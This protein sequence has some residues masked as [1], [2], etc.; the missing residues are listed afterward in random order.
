MKL[1]IVHISDIHL[2]ATNLVDFKQYYLDALLNDLE[3]LNSEKRIDIVCLTGDL[4]DKGGSS[5]QVAG[6]KY[7]YFIEN[8]WKPIS[9]KLQINDDR[10]FIIP[11]NHDLDEG[12]IDE[13][14]ESGLA[15]KLKTIEAVNGFV[16]KYQDTEYVA[17]ER[18]KEYKEFERAFYKGRTESYVSNFESCHVIEVEGKRIGLAC[19]NTSWRCY[20]KQ[21]HD[22]LVM[23]PIQVTNASAYF[24]EKACDFVIGMMHHPIDFISSVDRDD[25]LS[26]LRN[27]NYD[28]M[29]F[30]HTHDGTTQYQ[31]GNNG[32][33]FI[34]TARTGFNNP[35]ETHDKYKS[36]Y[37]II[38]IDDLNVICHYRLYV[39]ERLKFDKDIIQA[40]N[41]EFHAT[42]LPKSG[43][44]EFYKLMTIS[45]ETCMSRIDD[46]NESLVIYGTDSKAPK[47][48]NDLF[49]L[50]RLTDAPISYGSFED[51][52]YYELNQLI[53]S[54]ENILLSGDKES[55]K[56]T[57]LNKL[58]IEISNNFAIYQKIP[59]KIDFY[60]IENRDIKNLVKTFLNRVSS[61]E[62]EKLLTDGN[63][64]VLLDNVYINEDTTR[65]NSRL[66]DFLTRY[67]KIKFIAATSA[68]IDAFIE[69]DANALSSFKKIYIGPVG[70]K[71]F[72]LLATK[73]FEEKNAAWFKE[74]LENVIKV[75]EK[76]KISRTFFSVSLFLWVIE[77]K[78]GFKPTNNYELLLTFLTYIL[79][80]FD[81]NNA[82]AG[83]Y[84][85]K[86]KLELLTE[87]ALEMYNKGDKA[88]S[89]A[90]K[91]NAVITTVQNNFSLNQLSLK[92][93]S[94]IKEFTERG[95]FKYNDSN[96][97]LQFR[98][99]SFFQF[100]LSKTIDNDPKFK[101]QI[102]SDDKLLGFIEEID[103]YTG[104]KRSD[105]SVLV[106]VAES[107]EKNF[108]SLDTAFE[109]K[110]V[111]NHF[112]SSPFLFNNISANSV[113]ERTKGMK[114]SDEEVERVMGH[115]MDVLPINTSIQVKEESSDKL[116]FSRSLEIAARVLKNSENIK[117]PTTING[118]LDLV[119]TK[120]ALHSVYIQ[121]LLLDQV[122][123]NIEEV[124]LP[125]EIPV[126]VLT[127]FGPL[128]AQ[129]ALFKWGA[130]EFLELPLRNKIARLI[131]TKIGEF[132]ELEL[133]LSA[134]WY[135]DMKGPSYP[136]II[137]SAVSKMKNNFILELS[138][139][140]VL[141]YYMMKSEKSALLPIYE[142]IMVDIM[143]RVKGMSKKQARKIIHDSGEK[144][145]SE[146]MV[147]LNND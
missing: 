115:H 126:E 119:I 62:V 42:L 127:Y 116:V 95:I 10:L 91:E 52:E 86:K 88:D 40:D 21:I 57:I 83:S 146:K 97:T 103:F 141:G 11:G 16:T 23:G 139:L 82:R 17:I 94:K 12:L 90:L 70:A 5:F 43:K 8:F 96:G 113:I 38:D 27:S 143:V 55:G 31:T 102:I 15:A 121:S 2:S 112:P 58:F 118:V 74:N 60:E 50:P 68:D 9:S 78:V 147:A 80:G 25:V 24:K 105:K 117:S 107:L 26:K 134:F 29:L 137:Q 93:S 47:S 69:S 106:H 84:G 41:G 76:L 132:S 87:I 7:D 6:N 122:N 89:Y 145:R 63:I 36:G 142:R 111:D 35:R 46:I 66:S 44:A 51:A 39:N 72:K 114:L 98:F 54:P 14:M 75:F 108:K 85:F 100:F 34:S 99:E 128:I 53:A 20:S 81:Y 71:E 123:K 104:Y 67:D 101:E 1:R 131:D 109:G 49:V 45:S 130:T 140:K 65:I 61:T 120:S 138:Y 37:T 28:I 64:L 77:K 144:Y 33:V 56:S 135:A 32:N 129:E 125:P 3:H 110:L 59:V 73:W 19:L 124:P 18:Q 30:G 133:F 92:A 4:L 22:G 13:Y 79:E 136:D 48:V